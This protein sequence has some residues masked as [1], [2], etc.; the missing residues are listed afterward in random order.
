APAHH[1]LYRPGGRP[2]WTPRMGGLP[3]P[4]FPP[5]R[6]DPPQPPAPG[7]QRH[8]PRRHPPRQRPRPLP[9][10]HPPPPPAPAPPPP[11][12]PPPQPTAGGPQT[13]RGSLGA[14]P[15]SSVPSPDST[16]SPGRCAASAATRYF[17]NNGSRDFRSAPGSPPRALRSSSSAPAP[18]ARSRAST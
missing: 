8:R 9:P 4:P 17:C 15:L 5:R 13:H 11:P 6:A 14:L 1:Q 18:L 12:P 16:A 3:A 10:P 7:T 2:R